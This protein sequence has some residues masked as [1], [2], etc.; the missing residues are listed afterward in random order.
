MILLTASGRSSYRQE[1]ADSR[2]EN[3]FAHAAGDIRVGYHAANPAGRS[4]MRREAW[5]LRG[6]QGVEG[7]ALGKETRSRAAWLSLN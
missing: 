1:N 7:D 5:R 2:E 3:D 4:G 6:N